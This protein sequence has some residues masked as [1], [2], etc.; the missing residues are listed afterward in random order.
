VLIDS[1]FPRQHEPLPKKLVAHILGTSTATISAGM[2]DIISE[3]EQNASILGQYNP[4]DF[5][6]SRDSK[7]KTFYLRSQDTIDTMAACGV[8]YDWLS[9]QSDRDEAV[10]GWERLVGG[11]IEVLSIP[12]NHFQPFT[13]QNVSPFEVHLNFAGNVDCS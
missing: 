5:D 8:K 6:A 3:F 11:P 7:I 4:P 2:A 13:S 1:P 9:N 12:G 10:R